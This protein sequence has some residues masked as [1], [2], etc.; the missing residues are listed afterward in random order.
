MLTNV[1]YFAL[2]VYVILMYDNNPMEYVLEDSNYKTECVST[3]A[4]NTY[5]FCI[6]GVNKYIHMHA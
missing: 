6:D 5:F 4:Q 3:C 2:M 1:Q